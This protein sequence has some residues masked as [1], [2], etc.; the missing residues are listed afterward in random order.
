[1]L[2]ASV[3]NPRAQRPPFS[4]IENPPPM[5]LLQHLQS[6]F[7][8]RQNVHVLEVIVCHNVRILICLWEDKPAL[9]ELT[10]P[11]RW[12]V[13]RALHHT[14]ALSTTLEPTL[15]AHIARM[16]DDQRATD[17]TCTCCVADCICSS[18]S[19]PERVSHQA[20]SCIT[21]SHTSPLLFVFHPD[22]C[23]I[24]LCGFTSY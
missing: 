18:P 6:C 12:N 16:H 17:T 24:S 20:H 3:I 7:V 15:Y 2:P 14:A 19:A 23:H 4:C 8:R 22:M 13:A 11:S 21:M 10:Q 9:A 5:C 1:M